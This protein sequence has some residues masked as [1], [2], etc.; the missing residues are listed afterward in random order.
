MTSSTAT[1]VIAGASA[2]GGGLIVAVSN[3]LVSRA[4]SREARQGDLRQALVALLSALSQVDQELRAEPESKRTVRIVNT[5]MSRR[6][7]QID[8]IT[9]RIHRRVFQ[10]QLD[11]LLRRLQDALAATF[12]TAPLALLDPLGAV[13]ELM[14]NVQQHDVTWRREWDAARSALAVAC[15][16]TLGSKTS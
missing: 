7:P 14:E 9:D 2:I 10:P 1:A 12:L 15:R 16:R 11:P 13:S 8:Y 4:Q 3:Y 5:Q 6:F